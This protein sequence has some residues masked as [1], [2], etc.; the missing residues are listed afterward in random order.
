[1]NFTKKVGINLLEIRRITIIRKIKS[2]MLAR[3]Q[4]MSIAGKGNIRIMNSMKRQKM[5]SIRKVNM[6]LMSNM[7]K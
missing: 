3:N 2:D 6:Q 4:V 1:M 7:K 5:S